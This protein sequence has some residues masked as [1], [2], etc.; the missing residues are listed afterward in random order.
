MEIKIRDLDPV[1]VSKLDEMAKKN[2]MSR[3]EYLNKLLTGYAISP[4]TNDVEDK[5]AGLV[6][7]LGDKLEQCND[8]IEN[9]TALLEKIIGGQH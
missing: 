1:V 4:I 8:I 3:N 7:V 6:K 2:K 9:N 5:Y